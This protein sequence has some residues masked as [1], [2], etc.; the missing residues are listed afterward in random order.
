MRKSITCPNCQHA[1]EQELAETLLRIGCPQ[2]GIV[3]ELV[4]AVAAK[5]GL[6]QQDQALIGFAGGIAIGLLL[7]KILDDKGKRK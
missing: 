1:W 3:L 2:C 7:L 5:P 4:R 6:S